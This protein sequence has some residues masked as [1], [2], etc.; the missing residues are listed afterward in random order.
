MRDMRTSQH[1]RDLGRGSNPMACCAP[2][3][4]HA[5]CV[6]VSR[7]GS[8]MSP[9]SALPS[10]APDDARYGRGLRATPSAYIEIGY[11]QAI[12][13]NA[14]FTARFVYVTTTTLADFLLPDGF[15]RPRAHAV[16]DEGR[17]IGEA[18]RYAWE[19]VSQRGAYGPPYAHRASRAS[20]TRCCWCPGFMAGD[21]TLALMRRA[22]V[23]GLRTYRSH[24]HANVGCTLDAAAQLEMRLE[25]IAQRAR[26]AGA[27]R[28]AQ[29]R[30]HARPRGRGRRPDLV[31]GLVTM[32]SP[33]L[34]PG[35]HHVSLSASV[36]MLVRLS[37]A[38]FPGRDV[39]GLR[40]PA[41][42]RARASTRVARRWPTPST[43]P[44]STPGATASSTGAPA[45]TRWPPLEVRASHVGMA[46]DPRVIAAVAQALR[47]APSVVEVDRG[48]IA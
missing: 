41:P 44:R 19:A 22:L 43:S 8:A 48:E 13:K 2:S 31:S 32:G 26:H 20:T 34:A 9:S 29:P 6:V 3:G 23:Q 17:V 42:A 45:S 24:I 27:H 21:G 5:G 35:A 36:A 28:R 12:R 37:R 10:H 47:P 14:P 16:I 25:S 39:G 46:V 4:T 38:G 1:E 30:R 11:A 33:M 40:R 7:H 15:D 18:G